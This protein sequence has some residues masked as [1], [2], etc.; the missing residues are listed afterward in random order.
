MKNNNNYKIGNGL[1][2]YIIAEAGI[3]HNGDIKTAIKMLE[4]ASK[5]G[6]SAIKFQTY[7]SDL[8]ISPESEYFNLFKKCELSKDNIK[9][10]VDRAREL[11]LNIFSAVF[12]FESADLWNRFGCPFYKIASGDITHHALINHVA[13]F[14]KPIIISTGGSNLL[15]VSKAIKVIKESN[16][17]VDISILHCVSNYPTKIESVNMSTITLLK[18]EFNLTVGFSDHTIGNIAA[19]S[20][21]S[22]GASIIEKHFTLDNNMEGPDHI[23]SMDKKD[24]K[25]FIIDLNNA[26][27]SYGTPQKN[28]IENKNVIT[29][30]RR[31]IIA[32]KNIKKGELLTFE[33]I[34]FRRPA[35]GIPA[36]RVKDVIGKRVISDIGINDFITWEDIE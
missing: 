23:L 8:F 27:I 4:E 7:K 5:I 32:S 13:K 14:G 19:I 28:A 33:N 20:A 3:N 1:P 22:L 36:D 18:E 2:P 11:N 31:S 10:L 25:Q 21:I 35:I 24:F 34:V 29:A 15:E 16:S 12:D 30:I 17:E 6:V 9:Q 26:Y